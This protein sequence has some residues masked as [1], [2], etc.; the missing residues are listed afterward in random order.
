M[1]TLPGP[2][3]TV[4]DRTLLVNQLLAVILGGMT[5]GDVHAVYGYD[6]SKRI[7]NVDITGL[8]RA[9][10]VITY[11]GTGRATTAVITIQKTPPD[12]PDDLTVTVT[13]TYDADGYLQVSDQVEA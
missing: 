9:N 13:Y 1:L 4:Y 2:A 6:D 12:F 11:D 10:A 8:L 3:S 5:R 7:N